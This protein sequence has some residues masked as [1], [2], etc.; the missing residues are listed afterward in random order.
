MG[1]AFA[2]QML[3]DRDVSMSEAVATS[4]AAC[5]MNMRTMIVWAALVVLLVAV[6]MALFYVGL[7]ITLPLVGHASWHAYRAV[8]AR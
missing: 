6:G 5:V 3:L 4:F 8:I 7:A 1:G 2:L